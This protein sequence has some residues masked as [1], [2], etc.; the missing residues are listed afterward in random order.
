MIVTTIIK[1]NSMKSKNKKVASFP[2]VRCC[3]CNIKF[4]SDV[5]DSKKPMFLC[6]ECNKE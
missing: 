4:R 2:K 6:D 1:D 3:K 5:S